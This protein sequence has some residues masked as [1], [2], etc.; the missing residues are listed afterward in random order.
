MLGL[1]LYPFHLKDGS[2]CTLASF[3]EM[4]EETVELIGIDQ[5]GIG[6]DLCQ[7]WGYDTLEWMRSGR[8]TFVAPTMVRAARKISAGPDQP[9]WFQDT[10]DLPQP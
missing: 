8:W 6:S 7:N 5:L 3:C 9:D 10:R 1:S 2:A 4:I